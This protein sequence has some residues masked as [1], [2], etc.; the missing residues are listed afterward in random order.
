MTVVGQVE[1]DPWCRKVLAKHWPE[2]PRHD[3]VRTAADWW[4][5]ADANGIARDEPPGTVET[6][7]AVVAPEPGSS[8]PGS[9]RGA[10]ST[11]NGTAT[12]GRPRVDLVCGG[13]PCQPVS[14]A[15]KGLAQADSRW[16][17]PAFAGVIRALRPAYVLVENV[18]GLLGRGMGDVLGDLA[19]L[20]YDAEWD[21][22]PAA[23]VGAPHIRNRVWIVAY[24]GDGAEPERARQARREAGQRPSERRVPGSD[25][26]DVADA[27]REGLAQRPRQPRDDDTELPATQR[28]GHSVREMADT[29]SERRGNGS[30]VFRWVGPAGCGR[31]PAEP[32]VGRVA[33]G[34]PARVD[35]LRGL[36]NAVV[37]QVAEHIGRLIMEAAA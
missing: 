4:L 28:D 26:Q 16:L 27:S 33:H 31:W 37:P 15:G 22:V 34:I 5:L 24:P 10:G 18:P 6:G 9:T 12:G 25:G 29:G 32:A 13:F 36:G 1:I 14:L 3:D 17:W 8:E 23:F 21:S 2:V 30:R 11:T 35:R 19:A 7:S 20:G